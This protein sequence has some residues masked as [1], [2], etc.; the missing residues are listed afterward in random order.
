MTNP[1]LMLT[2]YHA[3]AGPRRGHSRG[4]RR[5]EVVIN[6][7]NE[8]KNWDNFVCD[9]LVLLTLFGLIYEGLGKIV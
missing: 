1:T 2:A 3:L 5:K 8:R 9:P 4:K 7:I 6:I